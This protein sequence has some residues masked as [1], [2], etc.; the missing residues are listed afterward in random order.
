MIV[1]ACPRSAASEA[2]AG[3]DVSTKDELIRRALELF[4]EKG[5]DR[6]SMRDIAEAVGITKAGVYHHFAGKEA[7]F[8]E[9]LTFFFDEMGKWSASRFEEGEPLHDVLETLFGSIDAFA[10]AAHVVLGREPGPSKYSLLQL[11]LS[12][13]KRDPEIGTGEGGDPLRRGSEGIRLRHRCC[14]RRKRSHE[15]VRQLGRRFG[16]RYVDVPG[17]LGIS[18]SEVSGQ[19]EGDCTLGERTRLLAGIALAIGIVALAGQGVPSIPPISTLVERHDWIDRGDITQMTFLAVSLV[20]MAALSRGRL[21]LYGLRSVP[22]RAVLRILGRGAAVAAA[23]GLAGGMVMLKTGAGDPTEGGPTAWSALKVVTS[24]WILASVSEEMLFRGLIQGFLDP[25]RSRGFR[26]FGVRLS[27]PVTVAA[28]IFGLI[29][30]GLLT[31][32]PGP[33]VA[34]IVSMATILGFMAGYYREKTGSIVPAIALHVLFNIFGA[35]VPMIMLTAASLA[36]QPG[37]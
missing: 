15:R 3:G 25:L 5:Y 16:D 31:R 2:G 14:H 8:H 37:P 20:L 12:A 28:L 6:T 35:V 32:M 30:L 7:L 26:L 29:H 21:K 24:I 27:L 10:G 23:A 34:E 13:S 33:M 9:V 22:R 4:L 36:G 1:L 18:Q 19:S 17:G 11:L